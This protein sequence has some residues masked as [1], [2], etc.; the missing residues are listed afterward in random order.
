[1]TEPAAP[2]NRRRWL[3][4]L[5]FAALIAIAATQ[6]WRNRAEVAQHVALL[7]VDALQ[8]GD[9]IDFRVAA[10]EADYVRLENLR[11]GRDGP[12]AKLAEVWF[13]PVELTDGRVEAVRLVG[14]AVAL[15]ENADGS[16]AVVGISPGGGDAASPDRFPEI[17]D[18]G[19]LEIVDAAIRVAAGATTLDATANATLARTAPGVFQANLEIQARDGEGRELAVE[20]EGVEVAYSPDAAGIVGPARLAY[21]YEAADTNADVLLWLNGEAAPS[22]ALD[23]EALIMSGAARRGQEFSLGEARGRAR[24]RL[25]PDAP[26]E[27]HADLHATGVE[28]VPTG[29]ELLTASL[30]MQHGASSLSLALLGPEGFLDLSLDAPQAADRVALSARG[31]IGALP[32]TAMAPGMAGNGRIRFVGDATAP[33][34]AFLNDPDYRHLAGTV[35]LTIEMPDLSL[36]GMTRDGF[37]RGQ[38]DIDLKEGAATFTSPGLIVGGVSLPEAALASLPPD[39]ARAFEDPAFLRLGGEGLATTIVTAFERPEGGVAAFGKVGVGLSNP[40]VAVFLEGG[41]ILAVDAAGGVEKFESSRLTM[42]LVDT[43]LGIA[44][45]GGEVVLERLSGSGQTY[46]ATAT[47]ALSA[48]VKAGE[49]KVDEAEID[50]SGPL[51]IDADAISLTPDA[52]GRIRFRGYSG[53]LLTA[54]NVVGLTLTEKGA[55]RFRYDRSSDALEADLAFRGF[56]TRLVLNPDAGSEA[57]GEIDL[58][59]AAAGVSFGKNGGVLTLRNAA[60]VAPD[61]Q[62][63]IEGANARIALG[64][65]TAERGRLTIERIRHLGATPLM[66]PLS[67]RLDVSGKGDLLRFTGGL[68]AAGDKARLDIRGEH[69]LATGVGKARLALGPVVFAPG[70]LQPQDFAPSL[71]RTLLET[72]GAAKTEAEFAWDESGMRR[73]FARLDMSVDKLRTSEITVENM[74]TDFSLRQVFSPRSAGPQEVR[75]GR[76]DVGV[77]LTLGVL[78]VNVVATDLI[79]VEIKHFELFGGVISSQKLSID[80]TAEAFDAALDVRDIDLASILAFAEFGELNATGRLEGR[81][82]LSYRNGELRIHDGLLQTGAGGGRLVYKPREI[83][84]ALKEADRSS[85]LALEALAN[86]AYEIITIRINETEA[87]ELRLDIFIKG[88]SLDVFGGLP[89]EFNIVIE[90]PIRQIIEEN[91]APPELPP[92]LQEI[93]DQGREVTTRP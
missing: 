9:D 11:F 16:V 32:I 89:I 7:A 61:H 29:V 87:E 69:N 31:E 25:A 85:R 72:I 23:G 35:A 13:D 76:L 30:D 79:E 43:S 22:G 27:A 47:M 90:G 49:F 64:T 41:A 28:A 75:I 2:R 42:R 1:M 84:A 15:S 91:L 66:S 59:L 46:D 63:A 80:P 73:E 17:P 62:L 57:G 33:A 6:L 77:P 51:R 52:G 81:L 82:P 18:I 19:R 70:V 8:I 4:L 67:L 38:L 55:R 12:K 65:K 40:N 50:L 83:D 78:G 86:F 5:A 68:I 36:E 3:I 56:K 34:T 58:S 71:Y 37:A 44:R 21:R 48:R 24:V 54:P 92:N 60:A 74:A 88:K 10:I 14:A 45:V 26:I 20:L 39:V 93:V 53:P